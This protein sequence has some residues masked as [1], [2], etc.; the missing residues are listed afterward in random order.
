VQAD[1][2]AAVKKLTDVGDITIAASEGF[3][4]SDIQVKITAPDEKTLSTASDALVQRLK[5]SKGVS[6]VTS[7]LS[8]SLP[9]I[10]V[11]VDRDAAAKA[12]LSEVAVGGIVFTF[13]SVKL[14]SNDTVARASN[15]PDSYGEYLK[16]AAKA[17][18]GYLAVGGFLLILIGALIGPRTRRA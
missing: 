10:A 3:G 6:Q 4:S 8:A 9:Y 17:P 1:V 2:R 5:G 12:G 15:A 14:F 16:H 11:Q 13:L 18:S 7:N